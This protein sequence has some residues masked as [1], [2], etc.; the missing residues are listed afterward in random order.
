MPTGRI[1]VTPHGPY[2]VSGGV[3]LVGAGGPIPTGEVYTLCRCG[4]S[5]RRPFCDSTHRRIAFD[6]HG[7]ADGPGCEPG[8]GSDPGIEV[9]DDGPLAVTGVDLQHEDGSTAAHPRFTLCRCG[10]SATMPFCD[11]SHQQK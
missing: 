9:R 8:T 2:V 6:G 1:Q 7:T 3:P 11:G 5:A 4:G 10:A